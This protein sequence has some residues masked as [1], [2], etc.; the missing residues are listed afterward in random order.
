MW[1]LMLLHNAT[2]DVVDQSMVLITLV[3]LL[4]VGSDSIGFSDSM[5]CVL[6]PEYLQQ[7]FP[8]LRRL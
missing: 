4:A 5:S 7:P 3:H 2:S 1:K 8:S 6:V